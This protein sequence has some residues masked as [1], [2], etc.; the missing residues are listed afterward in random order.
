ME[1]YPEMKMNE[2]LPSATIWIELK[3]IMLSEISQSGKDR[4]HDFTH[5]WNLRNLTDEHRERKGKI[6]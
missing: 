1:Y 6:R 3:G 4:Y 5:T 2:I